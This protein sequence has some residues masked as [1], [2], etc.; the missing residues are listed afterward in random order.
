MSYFLMLLVGIGISLNVLSVAV[1]QGAVLAKIKGSRL[2]LMGLILALWQLIMFFLGYMV[3]KLN[4]FVE[5]LQGS[6]D[7]WKAISAVILIV[8]AL[9]K[10]LE[11][12]RTRNGEERL[13]TIKFKKIFLF[14]G[15][16]SIYA[17][18]AGVAC[19]FLNL[20]AY[21]T[22]GFIGVMTFVVVIIGVLIGY[23]IGM[24]PRKVYTMGSFALILIGILVF[25]NY[26]G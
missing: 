16:N 24:A 15:L 4:Y 23:Y 6:S 8:I 22:G 25:T 5:A 7:M 10:I 17:F 14:A 3:T 12:N 20:Q 11:I 13:S 9:I 18:F 2:F 26:M 1:S 19:G 21:I